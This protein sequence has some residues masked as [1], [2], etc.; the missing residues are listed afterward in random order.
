MLLFEVGTSEGV[1]A[2]ASAVCL[3]DICATLRPCLK[4]VQWS[5]VERWNREGLRGG[6]GKV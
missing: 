3:S 5:V 4:R 1:S 2:A 6:K